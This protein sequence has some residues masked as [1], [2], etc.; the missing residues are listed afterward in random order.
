M[1]KKL[2]SVFLCLTAVFFLASCDK[3]TKP[4]KNNGNETT[5]TQN[6]SGSQTQGYGSE[7]QTKEQTVEHTFAASDFRTTGSTYTDLTVTKD[8]VEYYAHIIVDGGKLQFRAP[9]PD[10]NKEGAVLMNKTAGK[11]VKSITVVTSDKP[12]GERTLD[13]YGFDEAFDGI[14]SFEGAGLEP[15][16]SITITAAG[17]YTYEFES[18]HLFFAFAVSG[19]AQKFDSIKVVYGGEVKPVE[20]KP[21]DE[22][23][24]TA[25]QALQ[26]LTNY[27]LHY[28]YKGT[29]DFA[30]YPLDVT[31]Y[32]KGDENDSIMVETTEE[33]WLS[34]ETYPVTYYYFIKD[35]IEYVEFEY[36]ESD[37][38]FDYGDIDWSDFLTRR[39]ANDDTEESN[40]VYV[41]SENADF[42]QYYYAL[43][44][45]E[46]DF[47][48][49]TYTDFEKI[50][51]NKYRLS[52]TKIDTV[53]DDFFCGNGNLEGDDTDAYG[54]SYHYVTTE[55][56]KSFEVT[57]AD[58]NVSKI[59]VKSNYTEV[60]TYSDGDETYTGS[61]TYTIE[62][63]EI[64][65]VN[66]TIPEATEYVGPAEEA[67]VA[68]VYELEDG[69]SVS[70]AAYVNGVNTAE[71]VLYV[72]DE[73]GS[74]ALHYDTL[75]TVPAVG[76][77]VEF[78]ATVKVTGKLYELVLT[79]LT[80]DEEEATSMIG[81][82][83]ETLE[84]KDETY[85]GEI[86][87][88]NFAIVKEY[89][90]TNKQIVF[91]TI[92][93]KDISLVFGEEDMSQIATI[94]R[95]D[96]PVGKAVSLKNVAV[97]LSGDDFILR[98]TDI[99]SYEY[100]N[101]LK[102]NAKDITVEYDTA[103]KDA[104]ADL[105]V[106]FYQDGVKTV[107]DAGDYAI[108]DT[109]YRRT[110]PGTYTIILSKGDQT[111]KVYVQVKLPEGKVDEFT[112]DQG[113]GVKYATERYGV[114]VGLPSEGNVNVLVIP[115]MFTNSPEN[116]KTGYKELLEKGFN[117]TSEA[118]GWE[119]LRSYYQKVS[120]GKLNFTATVLD[121]FITGEAYHLSEKDYEEGYLEG[122]DALDYKYLARAI[123]YYDTTIDY[124]Q[125]DANND[126]YIDCVYMIY[127]APYSTSEDAMDL[128][129]AYTYEYYESGE[130]SKFDGKAIDVYMWLSIGFF[131]EELTDDYGQV[132]EKQPIVN[133]ET[134]IHETG[135]A[136]GLDDYYD[137]NGEDNIETGGF[138]GGIMMDTNVGDHDAF[139]KA[140]LG[141]INPT[142]VINKDAEL[143][144]ESLAKVD[145]AD[146]NKK[147]IFIAKDFNGIYYNEFYIIYLYPTTG[148]NEMMKGNSGLPTE[149]GVMILHVVANPKS[150]NSS[151]TSIWDVTEAHNGNPSNMLI[152]VVEADGDGSIAKNQYLDNSD[153]WKANGK[154][155]GIKWADGS[156]AGFTVEVKT[157]TNGEA[158]VVIDFAE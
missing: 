61:F 98:L 28:A 10:Q 135:H 23:L 78:T 80:I 62:F 92:G 5:T 127:L 132:L 144:I 60:D 39:N 63:S 89:D 84:D 34:G 93:G 2:L 100:S 41:T 138:G 55:T 29:G 3:K 31:L 37:E 122:F 51:D 11:A 4:T 7:T 87:N 115:V 133:A 153:L 155:E 108:D 40:W 1:L 157:L 47:D 121:A 70:L 22:A 14:D 149:T 140:L 21:A 17:T 118:T 114:N 143:T 109:E 120:Y 139:S 57:I 96:D 16:G 44:I 53:S 20:V 147:A 131:T 64:G 85:A 48:V 36:V 65:K 19:G 33:D 82:E 38:E 151:I 95:T 52:S 59:I 142:I 129:W 68:N 54:D 45:P 128:W 102:T 117:G 24:N 6:G 30:D 69:A 86:I 105:V 90:L 126:G 73:T 43:N 76:K 94:F 106:T 72:C 152:T 103:I 110:K 99:T 88:L 112:E 150:D 125:Y 13:F 111:A 27:K 66:F 56:Y 130:E 123:A 75:E 124:T 42:D 25:L 97:S 119:S 137:Y 81:Y 26:S 134:V 74:I 50:G 32:F 83:V 77:I 91:T 79:E 116:L 141:W 67:K 35:L 71:K 101:G 104:L 12:Y 154:L 136:L 58:G 156:N 148:V 18:S 8:G 9:K 146:I 113:K 15:L 107:L 49:L 46:I 158:T 145:E